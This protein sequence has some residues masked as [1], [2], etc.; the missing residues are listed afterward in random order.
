MGEIS[1]A[2]TTTLTLDISAETGLNTATS[3]SQFGPQLTTLPDGGYSLLYH[4]GSETG[5]LTA[6]F[7]NPNGVPI[8]TAQQVS[9]E[10]GGVTSNDPVSQARTTTL[11]NGNILYVWDEAVASLNGGRAAIYA[12][13]GTRVVGAFT[14]ATLGST[15]VDTPD[16]AGLP[17]GRFVM[18]WEI[19]DDV[20]FRIYNNDGSDAGVFDIAFSG[21]VSVLYSE[22]LV[23]SLP[24]GGFVVAAKTAD[25]TPNR[26]IA[27]RFFDSSGTATSG[28]L[29]VF[30]SAGAMTD[31][32]MAVLPNGNVAFIFMDELGLVNGPDIGMEIRTPTG[33]LVKDIN[34]INTADPGVAKS[35]PALTVLENGFIVASWTNAFDVG[36]NDVLMRVFTSD[37][38]PVAISNKSGGSG[39][40]FSLAFSNSDEL[41]SA[42][43]SFNEGR[44]VA[45]WQDSE[46]DGSGGRISGATMELTRTTTG[47]D[48][49]T[50]DIR[51]D[52]LRDT[53]NGGDLNDYLNGGGGRDTLNGNAGDDQLEGGPGADTLNGG[54]GSDWA[55]HQFATERV[56]ANLR[57]PN[58]NVG[59][60]AGDS[61]N[62]IENV[63]GSSHDDV[64]VGDDSANSLSGFAGNDQLN[65]L[66]G[67]D[68]LLGGAGDDTYFLNSFSDSAIESPGEGF[69]AVVVRYQGGLTLGANIESIFYDGDQTVSFNA[70]GNGLDNTI[71]GGGAGDQLNGLGGNDTINAMAG[72]DLVIGG[73]GNDSLNG[74]DGDDLIA[75]FNVIRTDVKIDT[76]GALINTEADTLV[77]GIGNDI[78]EIDSVND[79]VVELGGEGNDT[80]LI[81]LPSY[82]L[83]ETVFLETLTYLGNPSVDFNGTGNSFD[84]T[85]VSVARAN[86]L[87]GGGG[88]DILFGSAGELLKGTDTG[89]DTLNGGAGTDTAA[90]A[91]ALAGV[92]ASLAAPGGNT[93][94]AAGDVYNSVENLLGSKF[95]D[96]LT[97]DAGVNG[98]SGFD[99]NDTLDG[100]GGA[101][102]L[103]GNKGDDLFLISDSGVT[104]NEEIGEGNDTVQVTVLERYTLPDNV[105]N[106]VDAGVATPDLSDPA[107]IF[108]G[109][110]NALNNVM[111]AGNDRLAI[112]RGGDGNDTLNAGMIAIPGSSIPFGSR[113]EGGE[114]TNTLNGGDGLD[115]LGT[116][117]TDDAF[118]KIPDNITSAPASTGIDIMAGGKQADLY[119]VDNAADTVTETDNGV[120][121]GFLGNGDIV[122]TI[123][124]S[125]ALGDFVENLLY[126]GI[127]GTAFTGIGNAADNWIIGG[128]GANT[129]SGL[130]GNDVLFMTDGGATVSSTLDGGT[131]ED[132]LFYTAT[133]AATIDLSDSTQNTGAAAGDKFAGIEHATVDALTVSVL[134]TAAPNKLTVLSTG[135]GTLAGLGG[136]DIL[137]GGVG[138]D[139]LDGGTNPETGAGAGGDQMFGGAGNDTYMVDSAYDY[140]DEGGGG[141]TNLGGPTDVDA[142]V[143]SAYFWWDYFSVGENLTIAEGA[144]TK[145]VTGAEV[146]LSTIVG[147][148]F[149]STLRGNSGANNIYAN[150]GNDTVFAGAGIDHIDFT[151]RA[152]GATGANR[153]IFE[154][155]NGYDIVWNFLPG[156]DKLDVSAFGIAN[157]S[158]LKKLGFDDGIGN[159]F[160]ALGDG[161]DYLYVIGQQLEALGSG[162]FVFAT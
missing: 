96:T 52:A 67:T 127:E 7:Y 12:P 53:I 54:A 106:L 126:R 32:D 115:F 86:T 50:H 70:V 44:F 90:Y 16:A 159:C 2:T 74:G 116:N 114:G 95:G 124:S 55:W 56:V 3:L 85:L 57:D 28:L 119:Y 45:A 14:P 51:T 6:D 11:S 75:D 58:Q 125:Y 5:F 36:D 40:Q 76:T 31:Y 107:N 66:G 91:F 93:G 92:K 157:I 98:L 18:A 105:E 139:T 42:L 145:D 148:G 134:G 118:F 141:T 29:K 69:D 61:Y 24:N 27:Y 83:A 15:H 87:T 81:Y 8:G 23:D 60:A 4:N 41:A 137:T 151:D 128:T 20:A 38:E 79:T 33:A 113:L 78:I 161:T 10:T 147:G 142:I 103:S 77:G 82:A 144:S 153:L 132:T 129:L 111:T 158:A 49:E 1:V 30:P 135:G 46:T 117:E 25:A 146:G 62:S 63:F 39:T 73:A 99:G 37:G 150:W 160:F 149:D 72:A 88:N 101:D 59:E 104:V 122:V 22:V 89:V 154:V 34:R 131:G 120:E 162:D 97:G 155:G 130:A 138:N 80:A 100:G 26:F 43:A 47:D 133:N 21:G 136:I 71:D 94:D 84:N 156:T 112:L 123:L 19:I 65:G 68:V 17:D 13:D 121:L 110:G 109:T 35:Q 108:K 9:S 152:A 48:G 102:T 143:S 140:I 64:L